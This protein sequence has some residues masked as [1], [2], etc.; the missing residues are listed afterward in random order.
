MNHTIQLHIVLSTLAFLVLIVAALLA[1]LLA[2]QDRGL[3]QQQATRLLPWLPLERTEALLFKI[4]TVGFGLLTIDVLTSFWFFRHELTPLLWHKIFLTVFAWL[5]FLI[6]LL[7]RH[8]F[9]W[10]GRLAIRWT[11]IGV[12]LVMLAYIGSLVW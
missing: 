9:G 6:L 11:L 2:L 7:G 8:Y 1:I 12:F 3:R 10:R 5:V 4:L